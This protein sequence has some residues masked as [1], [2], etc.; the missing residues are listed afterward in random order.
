MLPEVSVQSLIECFSDLP[1]PRLPRCRAHQLL[2]IIVIALCAVICG[3]D[4]PT[5]MATFGR[6]KE[7]W[8][9]QFLALP[10]GIP[11]H[12]TFGR[13]LAALDPIAFT[14]CLQRWAQA[15]TALLPGEVVTIDGKTQ[16]GSYDHAVGQEAIA[17]V[18]AWARTQR[19]TLGQRKVAAD[20]NEITAVPELL[21]TIDV[22]DCTVTLDAL[23]CQKATA[24]AIRARQADYVLTLKGNQE[25]LRAG[26]AEFL[27]AVRGDRTLGV[28][29]A[30]QQTVDGEHG[31]IETR[32]YWQA[33]APD[34]LP[35][36]ADWPDLRSV[37]L[38]AAVREVKGV[39]TTSVRYYLSSL[40]V[41]IARFAEAVRGHWSI[42]NSCHWVLDVVFRED[43]SRLRVGHAAENMA[44]LRRFALNLLNREQTTKLSA[45]S[46]RFNAALDERYLVK[47]LTG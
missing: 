21:R 36:F 11:A 16:R 32:T 5:A 10:N 18:S 24:A 25:T 13:V 20:S 44:V 8:L 38:V 23:H 26:V 35:G 2:D 27:D 34:F 30:R 15:A 7:T 43:A 33:N 45:P 22:R 37:G 41:D 6:A 42:E 29:Y 4:G 9:R 47:I 14:A 19:L 3:G 40:P 31:R 28:T 12:D 39:A 46:K 1:D 17:T